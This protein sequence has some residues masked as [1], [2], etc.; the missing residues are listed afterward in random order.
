[1]SGIAYHSA[2]RKTA[3][4]ELRVS[5]AVAS[6]LKAMGLSLVKEMYDDINDGYAMI[7]QNETDVFVVFRGTCNLKNLFTD[8]D[9]KPNPAVM[10]R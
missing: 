4:D 10:Q 1:M 7:V 2:E 6:D 9:Y 8:L 5:E 3:A